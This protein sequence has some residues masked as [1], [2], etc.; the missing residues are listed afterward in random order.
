MGNCKHV[1]NMCRASPRRVIANRAPSL[2]NC[3]QGSATMM[4]TNMRVLGIVSGCEEK[5]AAALSSLAN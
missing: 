1:W 4:T 3:E 5:Y 2:C